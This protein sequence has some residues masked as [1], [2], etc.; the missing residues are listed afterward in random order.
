ML[1]QLD[2]YCYHPE[3]RPTTTDTLPVKATR[4]ELLTDTLEEPYLRRLI[5]CWYKNHGSQIT[6]D[7]HNSSNI[8]NPEITFTPIGGARRFC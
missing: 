6:N 5:D 1:I 7:H 3:A 4:L 2:S 8:V